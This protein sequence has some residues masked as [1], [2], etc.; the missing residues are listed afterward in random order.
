[1]EEEFNDFDLITVIFLFTIGLLYFV[2][3]GYWMCNYQVMYTPWHWA[4]LLIC[5]L[6]AIQV[7]KFFKLKR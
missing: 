6:A 5:G 3:V 4:L 7:V 2:A 1:M